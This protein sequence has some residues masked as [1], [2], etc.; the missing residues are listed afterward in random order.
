MNFAQLPEGYSVRAATIADADAATDLLNAC[1]IAE[2]GEP[3]FGP[4][5]LAAD[6]ADI[7]LG[8]RVGLIE[9]PDGS[10]AGYLALVSRGNVVHDADIYV[11]PDHTGRGLGTYLIRLSEARAL[12]WVDSAPTGKRVVLRNPV[13]GDNPQANELL[14]NLGYEKIRHFWRMEIQM[15]AEPP[16][17][18]L[19]EGFTIRT[20]HEGQDERAIYDTVDEAFRDHW[21][22][23]PIDFENWFQRKTAIKY[24]PSLWFQL[25]DGDEMAG[26]A[27][28]RMYSDEMGWVNDLAVR[29]PWR[30][31]GLGIA[32]LQHA[33]R[34]F[35]RRGIHRVGLGVDA[36]N[37]TGAT[38]LYERA[39]MKVTRNFVIYEKELRPGEPWQE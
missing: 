4:G 18:T 17:P 16:E 19:P 11:H 21:S 7:G 8:E 30:R 36:E 6:W 33:F 37:P 9:A 39:G 20:C 26:V 38:Q 32:L 24:D 15:D 13:N 31:R 29:K 2:S 23:G 10:F 28:C 35:Y 12:S 34:E 3:D 22:F 1:E 25:F 5:D 14:Q 27:I